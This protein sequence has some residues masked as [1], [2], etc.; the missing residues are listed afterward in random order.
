MDFQKL[1]LLKHEAGR[2]FAGYTTVSTF[3]SNTV[4]LIDNDGNEVH[5]WT[6]PG[7][8]GS[9]A[10]L[11]PGGRLMCSVQVPTDIPLSTAR[12]GRMLEMDWDGTILWEFTDPTQHHD[13][14][15]LPN[16]NTV[17][18][19]WR[20]LPDDYAARVPGGIPGSEAEGKMYEDYFREITPEGGVVWEWSMSDLDPADYPISHG[21]DRGEFA[22]A[23]TICPLGDGTFLVNFRNMD[24][25][26]VL[27]PAQRRFTWQA[28]SQ[29]WGRQHDPQ[30]VDG[31]KRI[32]FFA[33]G[34]FDKPKPQRSAVIELDATTGEQVWR[35][36]APIPWTFYSHVMGGVQRLP[37]G[38]TL[39]CESVNG[40]IF[41]IEAGTGAI[42]WDYI[43]PDFSA[44]F[45]NMTALANSIFR[46]YRY[47]ADSQEL[48]G[49]PL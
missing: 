10:Y 38:N 30:P 31:G 39:V 1:G 25:M 23:N 20:A 9:L 21:L 13:F 3:R 48:A 11:L 19:G 16:G 43:N 46:S 5:R 28:R 36:E 35:W 2:S 12:G 27:D 32:L 15:R 4:K 18:I 41:E 42:V 49:M 40:R 17:Y 33:N 45:P 26:A 22:H 29:Y 47:A 44:P 37:N 6:L 7:Q 14:R 24:L 34:A 8:L